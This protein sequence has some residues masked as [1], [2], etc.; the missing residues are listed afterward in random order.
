MNMGDVFLNHVREMTRE[1][2][3]IV[4]EKTGELFFEAMPDRINREKI[5]LW[6]QDNYEMNEVQALAACFIRLFNKDFDDGQFMFTESEF[7]GMKHFLVT[8]RSEMQRE[9]VVYIGDLVRILE[10]SSA[11]Q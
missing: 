9:D 11:K 10:K 7:E 2:L 6:L 8:F 4:I 3:K 5:Y 1:Q